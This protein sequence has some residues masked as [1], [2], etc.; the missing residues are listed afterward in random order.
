MVSSQWVLEEP[1]FLQPIN[2]A[3]AVSLKCSAGSFH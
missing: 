1:H 3:G 2:T